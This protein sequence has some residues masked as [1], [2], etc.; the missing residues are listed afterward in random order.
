MYRFHAIP[1]KILANFF[2][3]LIDSNKPIP[4]FIS[5]GKGARRAT[6][7]RSPWADRQEHRQRGRWVPVQ[8]GY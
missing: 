7:L 4:Q 1:I 8:H 3:F 2:F 5:K 6:I